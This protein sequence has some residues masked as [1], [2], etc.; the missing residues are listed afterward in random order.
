MFGWLSRLANEGHQS[1]EVAKKF[2]LGQAIVY[3]L[4]IAGYVCM[5][6][7]HLAAAQ[8]HHEAAKKKEPECAPPRFVG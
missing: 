3:G 1:E 5:I 4:L 7:Y 2:H 6:A 8:R